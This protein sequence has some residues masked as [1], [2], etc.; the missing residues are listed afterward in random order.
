VLVGG[1]LVTLQFLPQL[2]FIF[3]LL[4]L[5]PLFMAMFSYIATMLNDI[6]SYALGIALF[7]GWVLAAAF[8]LAS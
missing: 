8:P 3:L 7:F 2:S 5:F 1:F 6:W 4:P